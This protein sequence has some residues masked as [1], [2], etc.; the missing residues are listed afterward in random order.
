M[1]RAIW[2][3]RGA[4]R[5]LRRRGILL[6]EKPNWP[7]WS[8]PLGK[9]ASAPLD[10]S[11]EDDALVIF[12]SGT[13]SAPKAVVHTHGTLGAFLDRVGSIVAPMRMRHY[14]A[15]TPQ[16][17]FYALMS[18]ATCHIVRGR[19]EKRTSRALA[20]L[21][22]GEIDAWFGSAWLMRRW[23]EDGLPIPRSLRHLVLGSAPAPRA[24]ARRLVGALPASTNAQLIYGLTEVGPVALSDLRVKSEREGRGD[25]VGTPLHGTSLRLD[26]QELLVRSAAVADRYHGL[27]R[28]NGELAT[29]DLARIGDDGI[30][31]LGRKKDM[32]LRRGI[33]LYPGV[34]EPLVEA[35]CGE[36]A[37]VGVYDSRS[38]DEQIVLFATQPVP[39]DGRFLADATPDRVVVLPELPRS[40]RQN[41]VDKQLLRK[42][43]S[44][45]LG[46]P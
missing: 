9:A 37:L 15:E 26:D 34:L 4:T 13:T 24:F 21:Q 32:I 2:A 25:W 23:L 1:V 46:V 7:V 12:T 43:A 39:D 38:D 8:P 35:K 14:L 20:V 5:F 31:L 17:I 36:N 44:D 11:E 29:G 16:Q 41:K 45:L 27:R 28:L 10:R 6:P 33:N 18:D 40:G 3:V 22:R 19:G 30:W 42:I